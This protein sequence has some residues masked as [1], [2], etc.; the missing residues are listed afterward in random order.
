MNNFINEIILVDDNSKLPNS[1]DPQDKKS[2]SDFV[3]L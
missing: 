1:C 2:V 3:Q